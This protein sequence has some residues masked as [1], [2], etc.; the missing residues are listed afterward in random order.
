MNALPD[1]IKAKTAEW[2]EELH[3][4]MWAMCWDRANGDYWL[5]DP[6]EMFAE[7]SV[8]LVHL[9]Q[10]YGGNGKSRD[11]VKRILIVSM[12]NRISDLCIMAYRT[13]RSAEIGALRLWDG[14]IESDNDNSLNP[15]DEMPM[16]AEV[17]WTSVS[18]VPMH[19]YV[20]ME[21]DIIDLSSD[22]QELLYMAMYQD[23][24]RLHQQ[25]ELAEMRKLATTSKNQWSIRPTPLI[26]R[27]ALGWPKDRFKAAWN[28][29]VDFV[30]GL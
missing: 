12:R 21:D 22:A 23:D 24:E 26:F 28:E 13:H 9:V 7:L 4:L 25:M 18:S 30:S 1:N 20:D 14:S 16:G 19:S 27:R 10:R 5:L 8:E 11:E 6:E 3:N 15:D 17:E 29:V 2:Y